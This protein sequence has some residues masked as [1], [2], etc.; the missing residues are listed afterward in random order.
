MNRSKFNNYFH[1]KYLSMNFKCE[2]DCLCSNMFNV[3]NKTFH[4]LIVKHNN[5][6]LNVYMKIIMI[7]V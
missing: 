1:K 5:Y 4:Y 3:C 2:Y 6:T 7:N